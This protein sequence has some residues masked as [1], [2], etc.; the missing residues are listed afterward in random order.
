MFLVASFFVLCCVRTQTH[1]SALGQIQ[2]V[3]SITCTT[4]TIK[5][6]VARGWVSRLA[7]AVYFIDNKRN[8]PPLYY[9][10][11]TLLTRTLSLLSL[12]F[13]LIV[14]VYSVGILS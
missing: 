8:N 12:S 7:T 10:L 11:K 6:I 14:L 2:G 1:G 5:M 9:Y 13:R 3:Q 4:R